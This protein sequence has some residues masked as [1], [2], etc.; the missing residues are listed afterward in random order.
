MI[1]MGATAL[2]RRHGITSRRELE[3]KE[4]MVEPMLSLTELVCEDT[5]NMWW[6]G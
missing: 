5:R 4:K 6:D 3:W 1:L 2:P